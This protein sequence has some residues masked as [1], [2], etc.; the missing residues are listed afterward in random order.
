MADNDLRTT[1]LRSGKTLAKRRSVEWS[2]RRNGNN[3]NDNHKTVNKS[4]N[5]SNKSNL[6][7]DV[8]NGF[9]SQSNDDKRRQS[10]NEINVSFYLL[11]VFKCQSSL[12]L[13]F[14]PK[15]YDFCFLF[16]FLE[17]FAEFEF[18]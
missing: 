10:L 11:I 2:D 3:T 4:S 7:K 8:V 5:K 9:H 14:T 12:K 15:S 18:K 13:G 6:S 1:R 16:I 17:I